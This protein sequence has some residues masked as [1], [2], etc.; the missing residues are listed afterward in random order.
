MY[1]KD[2][3]EWAGEPWEHISSPCLGCRED[4]L[5]NPRH[6]LPSRIGASHNARPV[7]EW[8]ACLCTTPGG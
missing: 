8:M 3:P 7:I 5:E 2:W 6:Y 4:H 1:S